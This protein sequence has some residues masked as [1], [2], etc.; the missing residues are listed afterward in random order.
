MQLLKSTFKVLT[1]FPPCLIHTQS[2]SVLSSEELVDHLTVNSLTPLKLL[3][4]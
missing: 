4:V 2:N 1:I 3:Q